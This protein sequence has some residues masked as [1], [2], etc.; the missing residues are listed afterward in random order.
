MNTVA[1]DTM[2]SHIRCLLDENETHTEL[3]GISGER[4]L[5]LEDVI[6]SH[7]LAGVDTITLL[8]PFSMIECERSTDAS[9]DRLVYP[10]D[11][12][13]IG[14]VKANTWNIAVTEVHS[15]NS[16]L[17]RMAKHGRVGSICNA[18]NPLAF[19]DC[20][21]EGSRTIICI[22]SVDASLQIESGIVYA[23]KSRLVEGQVTVSRLLY[24]PSCLYVAG[25]V[26]DSMGW[27]KNRDY[28]ADAVMMLGVQPQV[29]D[30]VN[31]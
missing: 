16:Q 18:N 27:T 25:L 20:D 10:S 29:Q 12:I 19:E 22:P 26:C 31:G 5:S 2:V 1:I 11:A 8:A 9:G 14:W 28:K 24:E 15:V 30:Q 6:N 4:Q 3:A 17:Y 13:K 21:A 23:P 7:I